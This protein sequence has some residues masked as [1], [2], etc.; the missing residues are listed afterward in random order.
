MEHIVVFRFHK[1]PP[2]C[3]NR[4]Q[5]LRL[6]N[7]ELRIYGLYGGPEGGFS[8]MERS[9]REYL[10]HV[11]CLRGRDAAWKWRNGDLCLRR[12]FL[13]YGRRLDFERLYMIE[14]DLLFFDSLERLYRSVPEGALGLNGLVPL[15][16]I[17]ED[18]SWTSR[19]PLKSRRRELMDITA[20][21]FG[22][23]ARLFAALWGGACLPRAFLER[24]SAE[25]IP[26]LGNDEL[27][28]PLFAGYYG[29]ELSDLGFYRW[30]DAQARRFFNPG[31]RPIPSSLIRQELSR[32]NGPRVFHPYTRVFCRLADCRP[33]YNLRRSVLDRMRLLRRRP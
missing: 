9:L 3:R 13:D 31:P 27:R 18:W 33:W 17:E 20:A 1:S 22:P 7:P 21:R 5:L 25:E 19:E 11:Y 24:Y 16:R 30:D 10:E 8:A 14:W 23:P 2:V 6:F 4:L 32:G 12:W 15:E 26:D 29:F 28:V